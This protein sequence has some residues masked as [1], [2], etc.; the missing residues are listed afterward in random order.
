[1]PIFEGGREIPQD[2]HPFLH[3]LIPLALGPHFIAQR[4]LIDPL[5]LHKNSRSVRGILSI[6]TWG[7]TPIFEGGRELSMD[8]TGA[9]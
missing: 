2:G 8:N 9:E 4:D 1:M 7:D 3:L 5:F 6:H